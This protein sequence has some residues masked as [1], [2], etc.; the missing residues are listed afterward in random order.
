MIDN[1]T[2]EW[3]DE[4]ILAHNDQAGNSLYS[5]KLG[6]ILYFFE[7]GRIKGEIFTDHAEALL[8]ELFE[9]MNAAETVFTDFSL[10]NGYV[11]L[12][13]LVNYLVKEGFIDL[14]VDQEFYDL[15]LLIAEKA[16]LELTKDN[17]DFLYGTIGHLH[18]FSQRNLSPFIKDLLQ[19]M[20]K[21]IF[22]REIIDEQGLR[23]KNAFYHKKE[24][25]EEFINLGLAHG[26][27]SLGLILLNLIDRDPDFSWLIPK[28]KL[29][30]DYLICKL[31]YKTGDDE[32][33]R[34]LFPSIIN[35]EGLAIFNNIPVAWCYGDLAVCLFLYELGR[36]SGDQSYH[37][38]AEEIGLFSFSE[39]AIHREVVDNPFFCHGTSGI[40]QLYKSLYNIS[41]N[42]IYL[43]AY[44][45][46]IG[47]T[48]EMMESNYLR[49]PPELLP[50]SEVLS[51]IEGFVGV[52]LVL[53]GYQTEIDR[54]SSIFILK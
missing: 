26:N 35:N 13:L 48:W 16:F 10:A 1:A 6:S 32:R 23:I 31:S 29:M 20:L 9:E 12:P 8:A 2:L 7:A 27:L 43:K 19:R 36:L 3:F 18:Y 37:H 44:E 47:W 25:E 21:E 50:S 22:K 28:A 34:S 42:P 15:D 33:I 17:T 39:T 45:L 24:G 51:V 5:G 46:W 30:A 14:G 52:A 54:W 11:G 41:G 49:E 40:A 38:K 53:N 4:Q